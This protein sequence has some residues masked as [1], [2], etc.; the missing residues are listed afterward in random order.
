[1]INTYGGEKTTKRKKN[2]KVQTKPKAAIEYTLPSLDGL[3]FLCQP[4]AS[5]INFEKKKLM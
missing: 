3:R 1:M 4:L 2:T 5:L